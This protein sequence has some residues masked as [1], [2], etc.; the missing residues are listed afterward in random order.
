MD[1]SPFEYV[2][3][4]GDVAILS[5]VLSINFSLWMGVFVYLYL[6]RGNK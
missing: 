5:I 2:V 3:S 6:N 4:A 1:N